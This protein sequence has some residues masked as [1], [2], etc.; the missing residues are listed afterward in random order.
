M[1]LAN[2][3]PN[4]HLDPSHFIGL[5]LVGEQEAEIVDA[6]GCGAAALRGE[7]VALAWARPRRC[8]RSGYPGS[9]CLGPVLSAQTDPLRPGLCHSKK[10]QLREE[11]ATRRWDR[12]TYKKKL[13]LE[14][15]LG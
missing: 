14:C 15:S 9:P 3:G 5:P 12:E 6:R 4:F 1:L 7:G 11:T 10:T 8:H 2:G 13:G